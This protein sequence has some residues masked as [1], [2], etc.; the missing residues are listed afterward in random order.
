M[1]ILGNI[2]SFLE[3]PVGIKF[4]TQQSDEEIVLLLRRHWLTWI[5]WAVPSLVLISFPVIAETIL[6]PNVVLPIEFRPQIR[7][8]VW[9]LLSTIGI[10]YLVESFLLWYY[11]CDIITNKRVVDINFLF[12]FYRK[13]SESSLV[14]IQDISTV[15]DGLIQSLF[16]FGDVRIETAGETSEAQI[17]HSPEKENTVVE[18]ARGLPNFSFE[19]VPHPDAVQ[20]KILELTGR[21][22]EEKLKAITQTV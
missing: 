19:S 5:K 20:R 21:L 18:R 16:D 9:Y 15:S 2:S 3:K 4:Q 12:P 7:I 22:K 10:F 1:P 17:V 11:N 6:I 13:V 14:Q 8:A